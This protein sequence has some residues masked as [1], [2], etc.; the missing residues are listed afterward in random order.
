M[1]NRTF[2]VVFESWRNNATDAEKR[3]LVVNRFVRRMMHL[4]LASAFDWFDDCVK[5]EIEEKHQAY[6]VECEQQ[7]LEHESQLLTDHLDME[8]ERFKQAMEASVR[9][10]KNRFQN[11][12]KNVVDR[13]RHE[14]LYAAWEG[15]NKAITYQKEQR[16][17]CTHV[18]QRMMRFELAK[19][20]D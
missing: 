16:H 12:I 9:E 7:R 17:H 4:Q 11:I 1:V 5:K 15:L 10:E 18:V 8:M 19:A 3:R 14:Q 13:W 20:F 2:M 6:I